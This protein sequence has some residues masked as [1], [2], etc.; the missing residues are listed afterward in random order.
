[1]RVKLIRAATMRLALTEAHR[2][3]GP[4]ALIL[5]SRK[6]GNQVEISVATDAEETLDHREQWSE[7]LAFHQVPERLAERWRGRTPDAALAETFQFGGIGYERPLLLVGP[8]GAGKTMTAVKLATRLVLDGIKP[9]VINADQNRAGAGQQLAALCRVL[10]ADFIDSGGAARTRRRAAKTAATLIDLP[11]MDPFND[12]EM[13]TMSR[14]IQQVSGIAA[15]VLPAG[16]DVQDSADIAAR[17]HAAGATL[18]IPTRLDL[19]RRLGGVIAAAD[20]APYTFSLAGTSGSMSQALEAVTPS[21]LTKRL[22][23]HDR[24]EATTNAA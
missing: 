23:G 16:L 21:F 3:M 24:Q 13:A 6:I 4:E 20:V 9:T 8:P 11:G 19:T 18:L 22:L 10:K 17:F 12:G 14:M 15:L 2:L 1:M 7:A 5:Q